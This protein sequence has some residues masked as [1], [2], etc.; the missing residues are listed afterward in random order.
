MFNKDQKKLEELCEG[1][2][3]P[4]PR[5]DDYDESISGTSLNEL[6]EEYSRLKERFFKTQR[7]VNR[8]EEEMASA[9]QEMDELKNQMNVEY[10]E[11]DTDLL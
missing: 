9:Q 3:E 8:L 5:E 1:I 4:M 6:Q 11:F 2:M 10:P 7:E